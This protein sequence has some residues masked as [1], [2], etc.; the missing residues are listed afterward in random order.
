MY[1]DAHQ[2]RSTLTE[3]KRFIQEIRAGDCYGY[4]YIIIKY[5]FTI[6]KPTT[7]AINYTIYKLSLYLNPTYFYLSQNRTTEER[8]EPF[9]PPLPLSMREQCVLI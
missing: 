2:D 5:A 7:K 9:V 3:T 1:N 8:T 4:L 6:V